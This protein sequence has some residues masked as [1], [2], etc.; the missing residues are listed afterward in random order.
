MQVGVLPGHFPTSPEI[1][2][3][4]LKS[5]SLMFRTDP[6]AHVQRPSQCTLA[7]MQHCFL[8]GVP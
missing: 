7:V 8:S 5:L 2:L 1:V 3:P 4:I 6:L